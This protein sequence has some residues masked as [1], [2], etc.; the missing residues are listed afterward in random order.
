M[1][2]NFSKFKGTLNKIIGVV[3][4]VAGAIQTIKLIID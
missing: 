2:S 1:T 4:I 3:L